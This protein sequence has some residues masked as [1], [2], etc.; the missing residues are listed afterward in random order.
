MLSWHISGDEEGGGGGLLKLL[1]SVQITSS[2]NVMP[3]GKAE[4]S[5]GSI[6][7]AQPLSVINQNIKHWSLDPNP[8]HARKTNELRRKYF[9]TSSSSEILPETK[10]HCA[11]S[12]TCKRQWKVWRD[13][14][15]LLYRLGFR[16][17]WRR[18]ELTRQTMYYKSNIQVPSWKSNKYY[19]IYV[20]VCSL[21]YPACKAHAPC[22]SVI[23][24]LTGS[25]IFFHIISSTARFSEKCYWT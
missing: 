3:F 6:C 17:W 8:W 10:D 12:G 11:H 5:A 21:S 25:A 1:D 16:H 9:V 14:T 15:N 22:Y 13:F 24:G 19:I 20:C 23:C 7:K 4:S 2:R 18:L